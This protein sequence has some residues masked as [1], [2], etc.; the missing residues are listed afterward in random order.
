VPD[1]SALGQIFFIYLS[2]NHIADVSGLAVLADA[3]GVTVA[4]QTI[5]LPAVAVG[6]DVRNPL[7]GFDGARLAAAAL[8]APEHAVLAD[9]AVSWSF[10]AA[11]TNELAFAATTAQGWEFSGVVTQAAVEVP[12][13]VEPTP[14]E[15]TPDVPT[16]D[17]A[18][19]EAPAAEQ[20]VELAATGI[21]PGL[22]WLAA[23]LVAAGVLALIFRRGLAAAREQLER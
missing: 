4:Q 12:A 9:G 10:N 18:A 14:S 15:P 23:A 5:E 1:V 7:I 2:R 17:V 11:G 20:P 22:G 8:S 3:F 6:T 19:P 21:E 13:P 16:P